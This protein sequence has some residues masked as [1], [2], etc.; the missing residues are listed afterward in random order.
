MVIGL[1]P[2]SAKDAYVEIERCDCDAGAGVFLLDDVDVDV[3]FA[4]A[5]AFVF[6][7]AGVAG[8]FFAFLLEV[9]VFPSS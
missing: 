5:F 8:L 9:F 7:F 4:V 3:A 1:L 2:G 6:A